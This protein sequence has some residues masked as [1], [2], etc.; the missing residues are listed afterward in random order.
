[1][2]EENPP[3]V[4]ASDKSARKNVL[5]T[6][7]P[8]YRDPLI[9]AALAVLQPLEWGGP[10][11]IQDQPKGLGRFPPRHRSSTYRGMVIQ[12]VGDL[13]EANFLP[14]QPSWFFGFAAL[15]LAG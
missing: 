10:R 1:M 8:Q 4:G 15:F 12:V 13:G 7:F 5:T 11:Y 3:E 14:K 2:S 9:T 6:G